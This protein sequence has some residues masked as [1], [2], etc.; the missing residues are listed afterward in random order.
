MSSVNIYYKTSPTLSR[1]HQSLAF[2]R[3]LIWPVG[4]G[5]IDRLLRG[6]NRGRSLYIKI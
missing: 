2:Y 1:F 4:S 3:F 6:S 5:E